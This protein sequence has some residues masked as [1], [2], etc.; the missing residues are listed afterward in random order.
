MILLATSFPHKK[1]QSVLCLGIFETHIEIFASLY[2]GTHEAQTC[3]ATNCSRPGTI[4]I[5]CN[6][7][8]NSTAK[9][10]LSILCSKSSSSQEV[11]VVANGRN[12]SSSDL[13]I[14]VTGIPSDEYNVLVYDIG[15]DHLPVL[16]NKNNSYVLAAEEENV[17]VT[18][19]AEATGKGHL[20]SGSIFSRS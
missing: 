17:A 15:N 19:H 11:F 1:T 9:G 16:S 10:Y 5:S 12:M 3:V 13:K 4:N 14:T 18:T 20:Y 6:F 7:S 2:L 8:E